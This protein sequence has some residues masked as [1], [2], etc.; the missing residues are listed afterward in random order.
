MKTISEYFNE[1]IF[2]SVVIL[3]LV[4]RFIKIQ[5]IKKE[6][7]NMLK[8]GAIIIDVRSK[9]EFQLGSHPSSI[10][11]PLDQLNARINEFDRNQ[12]IVL[13]CASGGRSGMAQAIL[14]SMGYKDVSNAG[15]WMN[16]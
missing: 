14:K 12:K 8:Q 10:N 5:K 11:I 6:L 4:Y 9:E 16:L 7:P 15:S 3:F 13:C 2:L 1:I